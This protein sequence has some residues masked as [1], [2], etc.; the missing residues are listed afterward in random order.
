[1]EL[2]QLLVNNIENLTKKII[3][4]KTLTFKPEEFT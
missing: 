2:R 4:L 1:M 3:D